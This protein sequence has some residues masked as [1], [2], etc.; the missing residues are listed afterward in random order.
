MRKTIGTAFALFGALVA[1]VAVAQVAPSTLPPSTVWGRL[2]ISAGPGQAIPFGVLK[3]RLLL[4]V[5]VKDSPYNATGDCST[6][7]TT[8]I[9]GAINAVILSGG[10]VVYF[11]AATCYKT[12]TQLLVDLSSYTTRYQ[13]RVILRGDGPGPSVIKNLTYAGPT[14]KFLGSTTNVEAYFSIEGLR[15]LGNNVASSIGLQLVNVAF[16]RLFNSSIEGFATGVDA[17][18]V[19][20]FGF[21]DSTIRYNAIG[22]TGNAAASVTS[23][24]SWTFVNTAV[25]NNSTYGLQITNPNALTWLGGS[26]Q[27]NGLIGGGAGQ[28]GFKTIDAGNSGGYGTLLFD[29]MIFEGNGGV[30]DFV[31]SQ[32]AGSFKVNTTFNNVSFLRTD[33]TT[34]GYGT[35]QIAISG[36]GTNA[37]YKIVNSN[38]WGAGAYSASA[39]R[40]AIANTNTGA[41]VDVDGLTS[42]WSAT[43]APTTADAFFGTAGAQTGRINFAGVT[44]GV[45]TVQPQAAAGTYNWNLP[46][47]AGAVGDILLSGGGSST[48]MGWLADVAVGSVLMSGGVTT[49]PAYTATPKILTS[50]CVGTTSLQ[51]GTLCAHTGADR[52]LFV[53][54]PN[55]LAGVAFGSINDANNSF[56]PFELRQSLLQIGGTASA[57]TS[58][59]STQGPA[60]PALTSCGTSPAISGTDTAGVVTMGTAAPT[61]C[62]ITFNTTYAAAPYCTVTWQTNI[63]SM[64][65][66]IA[67]GAI[68]LVQTGTSSNKVNYI[69]VGQ[70]GG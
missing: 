17:T 57:G 30:G 8:A 55:S 23:P 70:T 32:Q 25:S 16:G 35:N 60:A 15:L 51:F 47:T 41:R 19:E 63:A 5:S 37:N 11:P 52:N 10:G 3:Q 29:G 59:V 68:T 1:A 12:T 67:A 39:G 24:N 46:I 33:L 28:F 40:P 38:F 36:A 58:H 66:T 45:I 64:Q 22:I 50:L 26:I 9:Q 56:Q 7:D 6:D 53:A 13:N 62:V 69:C 27:Y 48:A 20:Q 65:Y 14:L 44:S 61:G 43:E 54:N 34:V 49:N 4:T 21:H 18:D 42:F 31:S 2:G